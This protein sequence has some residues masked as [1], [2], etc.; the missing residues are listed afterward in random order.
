MSRFIP[1]DGRP[2]GVPSGGEGAGGELSLLS[3]PGVGRSKAQALINAGYHSLRKVADTPIEEL[4]Q[5]P[6]LGPKTARQVRKGALEA[7]SEAEPERS[8]PTV[9]PHP[10][11]SELTPATQKSGRC[12]NVKCR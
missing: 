2:H 5:V 4:A 3:L 7:L 8:R 9:V 6:G 1:R 12:V 10:R 11:S